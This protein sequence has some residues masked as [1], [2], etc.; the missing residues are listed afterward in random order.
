MQSTVF[1]LRQMTIK[2]NTILPFDSLFFKLTHCRS[3]I[4]MH[5]KLMGVGSGKKDNFYATLYDYFM[6]VQFLFCF[7]IK[8]IIKIK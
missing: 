8:K 7:E 5:V 6:F 1:I 2:T 3:Q 4:Y